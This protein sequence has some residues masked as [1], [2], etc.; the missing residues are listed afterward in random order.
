MRLDGGGSPPGDGPLHRLDPRA[1][2]VGTLAFV[3][4]VVVVPI[5][6][7]WPLV[8]A[9]AMIAVAIALSRLSL[10]SLA[11]RLLAFLPLVGFLGVMVGL[12]HPARTSLGLGAVATAIVVKNGLAFLAMMVLA[13]VT[14]FPALLRGM[15]RLG[16]PPVLVAT[17]HFMDRYVHVLRDELGRM[18]QARRA[19]S[20]R[21]RGPDWGV[22]SGLIGVL[23]LR[24]LERGE[25]VHGAMLARGWDGTIRTLGDDL[26][27]GPS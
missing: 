14:P 26:A 25:R 27:A 10:G 18:V 8:I 19:R 13:G 16:V 15:S 3:I 2:I 11:R 7:W 1:K 4:A 5:G 12:G 23:F 24:A 22:L 20:F 6:T 21:R 17:L 9:A